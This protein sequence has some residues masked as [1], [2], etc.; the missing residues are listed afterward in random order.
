LKWLK[1]LA[2]M[3][4]GF[5]GVAGIYQHDFKEEIRHA[6]DSYKQYTLSLPVS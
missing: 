3:S 1:I 4:G 2:R 6:V 5:A